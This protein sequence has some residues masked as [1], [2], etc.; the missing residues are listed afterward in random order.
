MN[1]DTAPSFS[2]CRSASLLNSFH[3]LA[4]PLTC[5]TGLEIDVGSISPVTTYDLAWLASCQK[6]VSKNTGTIPASGTFSN[7]S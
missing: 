2:S 1:I 7:L 5:C 4:K 3:L 6:H